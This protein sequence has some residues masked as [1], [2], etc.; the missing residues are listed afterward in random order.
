MTLL[1]S[2]IVV[3]RRSRGDGAAACA[4]CAVK[5]A[6]TTGNKRGAQRTIFALFAEIKEEYVIQYKPKSN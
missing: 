6:A 5:S 3:E 2:V 4:V 1:S